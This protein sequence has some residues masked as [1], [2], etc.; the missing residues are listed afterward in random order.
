MIG[1]M[2]TIGVSLL[3]M[4]A[5]VLIDR[6]GPIIPT[7]AGSAILL[8]GYLIVY[9][10][11]INS[12]RILP[13]LAVGSSMAGFGSSLAFISSLKTA[14]LNFPHARGTATAFPVAAFGL[15]AFFFSS[16][17]SLFFP[18]N[19]GRFILSLALVCSGFCFCSAFFL[20]V[21]SNHHHHHNSNSQYSIR[22]FESLASGPLVGEPSSTHVSDSE[23]SPEESKARYRS[24]SG[25][26][27][28]ST[29][30]VRADSPASPKYKNSTTIDRMYSQN[31]ISTLTTPSVSRGPSF[32]KQRSPELH[33]SQSSSTL[34]TLAPQYDT[35]ASKAV[36]VAHNPLLDDSHAVSG[37]QL[38][39]KKEFWAQF[40]VLG[41]LAGAGQMYIYSVGHIVRAIAEAQKEANGT[42]MAT[43]LEI[44][45]ATEVNVQGIQSLQVALISVC[46]FSG[47][48]ISGVMSDV[49]NHRLEMQ[50]L[51]MIFGAALVSVFVHS[52]MAFVEFSTTSYL[53]LLSALIGFSYG[54]AFGVYPTIVADTFGMFR[55]SQNWCMVAISPVFG[56]Y[57][58]NLIFGRIYDSNSIQLPHDPESGHPGSAH[59]CL[60][61]S[62]CYS[63]AFV[64]TS[65]ICFLMSIVVLWMIWTKQH[66]HPAMVRRSSNYQPVNG[67][68][69]GDDEEGLGREGNNIL[70]DAILEAEDE[71]DEIARSTFIP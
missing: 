12:L 14:A 33:V 17:S 35:N 49:L 42:D 38:L 3:G 1:M 5:G 18:G 6:L 36:A 53:W 51:W 7:F 13:L 58:F 44:V 29:S 43:V 62:S 30:N 52:I 16:L 21:P 69:D 63:K 55:Y 27:Y 68:K 11:Y 57:L 20:K 31:S 4:F 28:G 67:K 15:S 25:E 70:E 59:V 40:C 19:T 65:S 39:A 41:L 37:Y 46:N 48:L 61:G 34:D 64:Y 8:V 26:C 9:Y 2:G 24:V 10:C 50:R 66:Q 56:V 47:R 32:S 45:S 54:L 22:D 71:A 60:K 23:T